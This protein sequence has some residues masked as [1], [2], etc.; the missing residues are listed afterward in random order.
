VE[1]NEKVRARKA[2]RDV[3]A[4]SAADR[5]AEE[6]EAIEQGQGGTNGKSRSAASA[7][8]GARQAAGRLEVD[9]S[10]SLTTRSADRGNS[11]IVEAALTRVRRA[12]ENASRAALPKIESA[13]PISALSIDKEATARALEPVVDASPKATPAPPP[14]AGVSEE[15]APPAFKAPDFSK[16][17]FISPKPYQDK[18]PA[19]AA[20]GETF[21]PHLDEAGPLT[22]SAIDEMEPVDYLEREIKKVDQAM[23]A[24]FLRNESP[25]LFTH[26]VLGAVDI[27]AIAVSCAPFV[28]LT[29]IAGG[30][31]AGSKFALGLIAFLVTFFY[32]AINQCLCGR[33]FGMMLTNTR[34]VDA[35]NFDTPSPQ[36]MLVRTVGYFIALAPA[37]LGFVWMLF[38]RKHRGWHDIISGTFVARDF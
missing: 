29:Q 33:T 26:I 25:S 6:P 14:V 4:A 21:K 12:S 20:V 8:T 1:L 37:L 30:D 31:F 28:A 2:K 11:T 9:S 19:P 15:F 16:P 34:V 24:E 3:T 13:R 17:D 36:R 32:L 27:F 10:P 5:L 38:N 23:S 7:A 18:T 35:Y 22:I